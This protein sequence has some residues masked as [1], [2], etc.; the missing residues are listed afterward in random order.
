MSSKD[1]GGRHF[2][3]ECAFSRYHYVIRQ[4]TLADTT[5]GVIPCNMQTKIG[6]Q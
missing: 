1:K 2:L 5:S 3:L 4:K 6:N